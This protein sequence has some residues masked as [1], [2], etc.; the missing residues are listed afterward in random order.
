MS[1]RLPASLLVALSLCPC[2]I[3]QLPDFS[4]TAPEVVLDT[5]ST[6][7][8]PTS[9]PPFPVIGGVF[10]FRNVTIPVG[11]IVRGVGSRP[12]IWLC[13]TMTI[14]GTLSVAGA[15]GEH[16]NTLNSANIPAAGGAGG[17]AG[18]AGGLGSPQIAQRSF[19]GQSAQG[20]GRVA[21]LGG[22]GGLLGIGLAIAFA[23]G[24]GGGAFATQGD[25]NYPVHWINGTSFVEQ[26]GLG[27]FGGSGVSGSATRT[28]PGG[29]PGGSPFAD[30]NDEN[31]FFGVGFD[32]FR[33]RFVVGELSGLVGGSGGGGGGD[34]AIDTTFLSP[35]W[36]AD[37]KGGGGGGGGGCVV[38]FATTSITVLPT[39]HVSANGGNGGGGEPAGSS[40][41]GGGG[42]GGSGG[43]LILASPG[44]I[45]LHVHG[46]TFA[47]RDYDFVLSADGGVCTTG[48]FSSPV[49]LSK[50]PANGT[51]VPATFGTSYDSEGLGG[52]GGMGVVELATRPGNNSDG[53]NTV[54]DDNIVL[55]QNGV[56]LT[57]A[58]KQRFLA[59]RG[60]KNAAGVRVDDFGNPTNIG[61][62]EGDIRPAPVL[63]PLQ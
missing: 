22:T 2:L 50:Y 1:S 38:V 31:D 44:S 62:N 52:F 34:L 63:L 46:E 53:T 5:D 57:G 24:G 19:A 14:G 60:W 51:P 25:P 29:G 4:P 42:G 8:Q 48:T 41:Q 3:A 36:V 20:P 43:L 13:D 33:R 11:T 21:A 45:T 59:W 49:V 40:N 18:G 55:M 56:P 10:Q 30:G 58:T 35:N 16:V 54:L 12:M 37:R 23:A 39:G 27:G 32:V 47:N 6:V 28:L 61:S 9:G 26:L 17:A 7:I 15:D